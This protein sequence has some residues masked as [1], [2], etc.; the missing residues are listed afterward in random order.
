MAF[1]DYLFPVDISYGSKGGPGF[2][3][4]VLELS[5]GA[6]KRNQNWQR[7]RAKYDVSHGIKSRAQMD[8]LTAF[9][10]TA[11]GR[12]HSFRFKD[13]ADYIVPRETIGTTDTTTATFQMIKIYTFDTETYTRN[14]SKP[15]ASGFTAWVNS[16]SQ[17][18]VY[19]VAPGASEVSINT[20]TGIVTIG[21]THAAT[22][23]Q[24]VEVEGEF[25]VHCRFETD[26][27]NIIHDFWETMSW[28]P[29]P[30]WEIKDTAA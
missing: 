29:I 25:D 16:V 17:V 15:I 27:L 24:I 4:T 18:V 30:I 9:F 6:E 12:A 23:G 28:D 7:T 10:Y 3:T 20:T 1:K 13:W 8:L 11:A 22:T 14:I 19:D 2:N 26:D 21:A 5:S